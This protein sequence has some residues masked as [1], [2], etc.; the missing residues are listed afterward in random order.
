VGLA[1]LGPLALAAL[2]VPLRDHM[3]NANVALVLVAVVVLAAVEGGRQ[4]GV[5]A[6]IVSALSF[7]FWFTQ[8]YE[9]LRVASSADIETTV[10]LLVVG[11]V[12]GTV[13]ARGRT[14]RTSAEARRGEVKRIYRLAELAAK[15]EDASDVIMAAQAE[16]TG[17]L[18][19]RDCRFEAPPFKTQ[20]EKLERSGI[21]SWHDYRLRDGGFELPPDGVELPVLGRGQVL[22]RFVLD[23]NPGTGVSLEQ[24]VVA[25][26]LADQVGGVLAHG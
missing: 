19:L 25:V 22:G 10:L 20:L 13:S 24:R 18:H 11:L 16:L 26:A 23:P 7:D 12:V 6:A 17:L 4:A 3:R 21:V 2:L 15:G 1:G 5:V 8:P 9:R 14:A